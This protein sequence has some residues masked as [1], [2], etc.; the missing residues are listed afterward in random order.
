MKKQILLA[1]A[2]AIV[3]AILFIF[4]RTVENKNLNEIVKKPVISYDIIAAIDSAKNLLKPSELSTLRNLEGALAAQDNNKKILSYNA[5]AAFWKDSIRSFDPY[6]FYLIEAAK[7]ENSENKLTFAAHLMLDNLRMQQDEVKAGWQAAQAID[8]FNR[9]IKLNPG[10]DDLRVGLGSAYIFG[11]G[12][13]G[14]SEATMSGIK[15]LLGVA[16]RDSTNMQAQLVLGVGGM[17]SG[18]FDKARD[19]FLKIVE[20]DPKNLEAVAYLA[21]TYATMGE[22]AEAI[23]WYI[24]SKKMAN[25]PHY[26]KE[27]DDRIKKLK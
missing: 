25:N 12:R 20:K 14:D 1:S 23:K 7:L 18:Q 19:R 26:T 15:E 2:G 22:K 5:L 17:I 21:D 8:L 13:T 16:E 3:I 4:G 24:I 27:V 10:N 11:Q 9:A 6:S